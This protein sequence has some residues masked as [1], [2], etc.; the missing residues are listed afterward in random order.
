M[1][2][3]QLFEWIRDAKRVA[4]QDVSNYAAHVVNKTY[5]TYKAYEHKFGNGRYV[6]I[7][8]DASNVT[9][10]VRVS[11][12]V[13][14]TTVDCEVIEVQ[15]GEKVDSRRLGKL[16]RRLNMMVVVLNRLRGVEMSPKRIEIILVLNPQEKRAPLRRHK[17]YCARHVNNGLTSFRD[18]ASEYIYIYRSEDIYKVMLHELIHFYGL[19]FDTP[20]ALDGEA[21][22]VRDLSGKI[23][24]NEAYTE[25]LACYLWIVMHVYIEY[26]PID[27]DTFSSLLMKQV[28]KSR[29]F[30]CKTVA[31]ILSHSGTTLRRGPVCERYLTQDTHVF[32]YFVCKTALFF[33]LPQFLRLVKENLDAEKFIELVDEALNDIQF[34]KAVSAVVSPTLSMRMIDV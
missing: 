6:G 21:F 12:V 29:A 17:H 22:C 32:S 14:G 20:L 3:L 2:S 11:Y 10:G 26:T 7:P 31:S 18:G 28:R 13:D 34:A 5:E 27:A 1:K 25:T 33:R 23:D 9:K 19:D 15:D 4:C 8:F 30:F 16:L 24:L